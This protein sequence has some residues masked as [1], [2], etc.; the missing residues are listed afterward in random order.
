MTVLEGDALQEFVSRRFRELGEGSGLTNARCQIVDG[1]QGL[2]TTTGDGTAVVVWPP[3]SGAP[4][5]DYE[6]IE[7][8]RRSVLA[9]QLQT[10][11][12]IHVAKT[13]KQGTADQLSA[14]PQTTGE[15]REVRDYS[16]WR[17]FAPKG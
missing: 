10:H 4:A 5:G 12:A 14:S 16:P 17:A 1:G 8:C 11:I 9:M 3:R 13:F 2:R 15:H 7:S 6:R